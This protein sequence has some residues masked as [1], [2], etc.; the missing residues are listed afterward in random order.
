MGKGKKSSDD[1]LVQFAEQLGMFLGTARAKADEWIDKAKVNPELNR[2]RAG[3]ENLL[4]QVN[5]AAEAAQ[6]SATEAKTAKTKTAKPKAASTARPSRG[7]NVD[8]PGKKHRKP[9]PQ[10]ALNKRMGEVRGKHMGKKSVKNEMKGR[11]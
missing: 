9:P 1:A 8:A 11:G 5:R 4:M 10:E 7:P 2:I 6:K 3:A